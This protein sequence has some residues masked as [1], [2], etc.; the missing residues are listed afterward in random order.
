MK[1]VVC[2]V[3][4]EGGLFA[5]PLFPG[6]QDGQKFNQLEMVTSFTYTSSLVKI[7]ARN[8]LSW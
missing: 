4:E 8:E 7:D 3:E 2:W 1:Q 6:A 5:Q